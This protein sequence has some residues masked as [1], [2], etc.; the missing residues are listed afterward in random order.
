[1]INYIR[2]M[3][4]EILWALFISL[5]GHM[6]QS[7]Q[8]LRLNGCLIRC[9]IK[10]SPLPL[11]I[12]LSLQWVITR[13][14]IFWIGYRTIAVTEATQLCILLHAPRMILFLVIHIYGLRSGVWF[15]QCMQIMLMEQKSI[16]NEQS[17]IVRFPYML[18]TIRLLSVQCNSN[19][20]H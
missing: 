3:H 4:L 9:G 10:K 5:W 8:S 12:N 19:C 1:M 15:G 17:I 14:H 18:I 2:N 16:S 20:Y 7:N 11:N 13:N 6:L